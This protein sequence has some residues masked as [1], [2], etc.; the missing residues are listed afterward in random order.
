MVIELAGSIAAL[1][2]FGIASPNLYRSKLWQI[3]SDNGFN[4]SPS[5]RL[6]AYANYRPLPK[7]PLVWSNFLTTWNVVVS[8]LSMF[9]QLLK[10]TMFV[11][12]VWL[13]SL[14]FLVNIGLTAIWAYS[15]YGQV[16]P[17]MSDPA[18]PSKVAWYVAKSCKYAEPSG[19]ERYCL[20]AKGAFATTVIM[21]TLFFFNALLAAWS[22]FPSTAERTA[23]KTDIDEFSQAEMSKGSPV[24]DDMKDVKWEMKRLQATKQPFTPRT[25]AFKTL[26]RQLPLRNS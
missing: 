6:Y 2:L 26:D 10:V 1:T 18:H 3:G 5:S 11:M 13:P 9:I 17:D 24:S 7:T 20:Q 22:M 21:M 16:G 15:L 8:V 23:H 12:H 25:L 4:S 14:G 19:Y